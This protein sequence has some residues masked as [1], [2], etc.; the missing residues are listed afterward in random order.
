MIFDKLYNN[1]EKRIAKLN[2][3]M[4]YHAPPCPNKEEIWKSMEQEIPPHEVVLAACN[5]YDCGWVLDTAWWFDDEKCWM[6]TGGHSCVKT[7]LTYTHWRLLPES[8]NIK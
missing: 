1:K 3:N 7:D 6:T 5:T 4:A 8:P 2:V